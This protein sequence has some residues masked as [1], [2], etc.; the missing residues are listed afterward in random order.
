[1]FKKKTH[2]EPDT[3][4]VTMPQVEPPSPPAESIVDEWSPVPPPRKTSHASTVVCEV[5]G[6]AM[7]GAACEVDGWSANAE[8]PHG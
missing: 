8:K 2:V 6:N 3:R 5:C 1:M 4:P 7:T